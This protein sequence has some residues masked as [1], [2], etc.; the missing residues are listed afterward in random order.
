[1]KNMPLRLRLPFGPLLFSAALLASLSV[2]FVGVRS[3][4]DSRKAAVQLA[5]VRSRNLV[6][7]ADQNIT[8]MLNRIDHTLLSVAGALE[9]G[10]D[11]ARMK[12]I[13]AFEEQHLPEA[14][15]IRVT[16][17]D[18][19]VIL[20][21]NTS[22]PSTAS[23]ADH[24]FFPSLKEHPEAGLFVTKPVQ[25]LFTEKW[26]IPCARRY[27]LPDGRF[28]GI[29]VA[30][31]LLEQFEKALGGYEVGPGGLR[32]LRDIDGGFVAR[33]P[34]VVKGRTI[35]V[36]DTTISS[37]LQALLGSGV[38][39]DTFFSL[40]PYDQTK[41]TVT[42]RRMQAAP[43]IVVA[44]LAEED[45][46][47]QWY[48]DRARTLAVV[49]AF[50]AGTW[51]MAGLLWRSWKGHKSDAEALKESEIKYRNLVETAQELVWKC[52]VQG[53]FTYLN[54]AWEKTHG[55]NIEEML[56]RGFGEFQRPE[57]FER[58]RQEF[59]RELAGGS[60]KEYETTHIARD[61]RELTLLFNAV[62]E[63]NVRGEVIGTQGTAIDITERKQAEDALKKSE[64]FVN[65]ILES[66]DDGLIVLDQE[67]RVISANDAYLRMA[68][69]SEAEV[70]GNTC[71]ELAHG[72]PEICIN[73]DEDCP[74]SKT[75]TTGKS[76]ISNHKHFHKGESIYTEIK[77]YPIRNSAGEI[78]SVIEII[79]DITEKRKFEEE[80]V[81]TQKLD[82][83]G[84]LAG[85]IAHDF[86][87]SLAGI[88]GYLSLLQ[89]KAE[90]SLHRYIIE[91][92]KGVEQARSLTNQLLTFA[93]GG[94][95]VKK[96]MQLHPVVES[97]VKLALSGKNVK[98]EIGYDPDL[99]T[100]EA[101][102]GQIK[103]VIQNIVLNA[104]QS[105]PDGGKVTVGLHNVSFAADT[106]SLRAG[107][108]L[109]ITINDTGTGIPPQHLS[110]IFDPYFTTKKEGSGLGLAT[111]FSI[112]KKHGGIIDVVSTVN[113]GTTFTIFLPTTSGTV[114]AVTFNA[115]IAYGKGKILVLEDEGGVADVTKEI[116]VTL[117]Y[118]PDIAATGEDA[119][120]KYS[121]ALER[122]EPFAAVILDL[123]IRG[124]MGGKHTMQG[125]LVLNPAVIGIVASGYAQD[126]V[127]ANFSEY[128]FKGRIMKPYSIYQLSRTLAEVI[129]TPKNR[130]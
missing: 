73:R 113:Q 23:L 6:N 124:G 127:M 94:V 52:D 15:A 96:L 11:P 121:A 71:H 56:G 102:E 33:Y 14:V 38:S 123:T 88:L 64:A 76:Y 128:G 107:N 47:A 25:G 45:Y 67:F 74:V 126:P 111:S 53:R 125:L 34:T 60:V 21:N 49:A 84:V 117:G 2:S 95:P 42:F 97:A 20:D 65:N 130:T 83:I 91:A 79:T 61:G 26:A 99:K 24:P 105:M 3:L 110:R 39:Q 77:S 4:A 85:G 112:I 80:L 46:L 120:H 69:K 72:R 78:T 129:S 62:P 40:T 58:D 89:I 44:G 101:D 1:M 48:K 114:E 55:Y 30:S 37:E 10:L 29:V 18:G 22:D 87:N 122:G 100:V 54:P 13:L 86:N 108:Y 17:A 41:R 32:T 12:H 35:A 31:V 8:A 63:V 7:S 104:A 19:T 50:F 16:N 93:K 43:L 66:I 118:S 70:I 98:Y 68:G 81:K 115:D 57:V 119:L 75:F 106:L 5:E 28:S 92:E 90:P 82:S 36:G 116:L 51:I 27:N 9:R 103:Q 109:K 59:A